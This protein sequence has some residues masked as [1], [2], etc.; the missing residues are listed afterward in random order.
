LEQKPGPFRRQ[1]SMCER[2]RFF[3]PCLV[4][5]PFPNLSF[6]KGTYY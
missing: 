5:K 4:K 2:R 6:S 3:V 1:Q